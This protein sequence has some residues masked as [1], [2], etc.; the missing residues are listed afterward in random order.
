MSEA[1]GVPHLRK[2]FTKLDIG[3]R[4]DLRAMSP[5]AQSYAPI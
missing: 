3:S 5:E 4:R 1:I 2:V